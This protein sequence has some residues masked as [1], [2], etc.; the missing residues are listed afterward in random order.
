MKTPLIT[1]REFLKLAGVGAGAL[2]LGHTIEGQAQ[3]PVFPENEKLGRVCIN[4][5]VDIRLRP[6]VDSSSVGVLYEDAVVPWLREVVGAAPLGRVSR[7]WVETPDGYI[8]APSL[9]PVRNSP[10]QPLTEIP[11]SSSGAGFWGEVT[12]P[13]VDLYIANGPARSPSMKENPHPRLYYSQV[14]WIDGIKMSSQGTPL[15][16]VNERYGTL[17]D[18]FWASADAF[19]PISQEEISPIHP[20]IEDKKVVVN[21]DYQ[22]MACYEGKDEVYFCRISSGGKWDAEGNI[23]DKWSTPVGPH[24]IWRKLI[25]IHMIGGTTGAGYDLPGIAWTSLFSGDGVAVHSTFWHNDFGVPRS[26]GCVNAA[27]ED[28]KWIFRWTQPQ[29]L[30]D[31]GDQTVQW[32]G[33]TTV[34]VVES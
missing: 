24:P 3:T 33:G 23:V 13:Y 11:Q 19:R 17:G 16:R 31:P 14:M 12:V 27:P 29:V 6:S 32:P 7:R 1:R 34:E 8:Y 26:H 9:Q 28:A 22:T 4:G 5:K 15:Y 18:I 21:V 30:L 2:L 25:S 20:E 10:N